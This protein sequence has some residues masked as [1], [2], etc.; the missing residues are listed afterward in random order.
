M[1]TSKEEQK[2][3]IELWKDSGVSK[4]EYARMKGLSVQT[5][6]SWFRSQK[7]FED[8]SH[9]FV[10][11][12]PMTH[13]NQVK[14]TNGNITVHMPSGYSIELSGNVDAVWFQTIVQILESAVCS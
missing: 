1:R 10:Q 7:A 12:S 5:F 3:H 8:P 9:Q 2:K 4:T 14:P 6:Y 11:V 13:P